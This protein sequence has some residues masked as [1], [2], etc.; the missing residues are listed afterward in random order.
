VIARRRVAKKRA[1][2]KPKTRSEKPVPA[3]EPVVFAP[4][5][6]MPTPSVDSSQ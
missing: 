3:A 2:A 5:A 4:I 6:A 1:V